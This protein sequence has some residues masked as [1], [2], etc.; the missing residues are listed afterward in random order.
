MRHRRLSILVCC[1]AACGGSDGSRNDADVIPDTA[2]PDSRADAEVDT[3]PPR[4]RVEAGV[5]DALPVPQATENE[6]ALGFR[7]NGRVHP[8]GR[9]ATWH[10]EYGPTAEYGSQT[11]ARALPGRLSAHFREDWTEGLNGWN[12]G[13]QGTSLV[14]R[15]EGE[16]VFLRYTDAGAAEND[17]NH[18]DGVGLIHLP[19]YGYPGNVQSGVVEQPSLYLGGGHPD[20]RGAKLTLAVRGVDWVAKGTTLGTWTQMDLDASMADQAPMRRANWAH[21]GEPFGDLLL[22]GEW[23]VAAWTLR[24]RTVDWTYAGQYGAR[25]AYLY[26]E[27][28]SG[29]ADVNVDIFPAQLLYV[30]LFDLPSGGFDFDALTIT[31]RNHSVLAASNG[32][33]LVASPAAGRDPAALVDGRRFGDGHEWIGAAAAGTTFRYSFAHPITLTSVLVHNSLE[34]PSSSVDVRVSDDGV[35]FLSIGARELPTSSA[36]GPNFHFHVQFELDPI[37]TRE[38]PLHDR[39]IVALE[40]EILAGPAGAEHWG[41]GEIEAYGTGAIEETEDEWYDVNRDVIA[42]PGTYHHRIVVTTDA[43]TVYGDDVTIE[44]PTLPAPKIETVV[45]AIVPAAGGEY[46]NIYGSDLAHHVAI[47]IGGVTL[48]PWGVARG[49]MAVLMP[50]GHGTC[51]ITITTGFGTTTRAAAVAYDDGSGA[52]DPGPCELMQ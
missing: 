5:S 24:N 18:L 39:P 35:R 26:K 23:E 52:A 30:D 1:V 2:E 25:N 36:Y 22:S 27:L 20:L 40:V 43:G 41:L 4:P 10:V 44:V 29:L 48:E 15:A 31:Y 3:G 32:A 8:A 49:I 28:E 19:M 12:G 13:F 37:T 47:E 11:A 17:V 51:D 45:P 33:R 50:P 14:P 9:P 38:L 46:I 6:A 16:R 42:P 34:A 21:T 7:V